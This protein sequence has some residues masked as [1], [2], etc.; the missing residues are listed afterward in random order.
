[1]SIFI[2]DINIKELGPLKNFDFTPG[3]LNL[4]YS[5]NEKGKTIMT[6]FL[7]RSLFKKIKTWNLREISG[8]GKVKL[9]LN[10]SED[11]SF[12]PASKQKLD[13]S[14]SK[15]EVFKQSLARLLVVKGGETDISKESGGKD[16]LK[17][18]L[19]GTDIIDKLYEDIPQVIKKAEISNNI[20]S[21]NNQGKIKSYFMLKKQISTFE[22]LQKDLENKF[23]YADYLQ[24]I[25]EKTEVENKIGLLDK[26]KKYKAYQ[27]YNKG[28]ELKKELDKIPEDVL[29][30]IARL[31]IQSKE[32]EER[33]NKLDEELGKY[34]HSS[35]LLNWLESAKS[36]YNL[37]SQ[38]DKAAPGI[39]SF[40][41]P[42]V[43]FAGGLA[44][45]FFNR[46]I[47]FVLLSS[48][49][50]ALLYILKRIIHEQKKST[51]EELN[52]LKN[53]FLSKFGKEAESY[54]SFEA[55]YNKYFELNQKRKY[56]KEDLEKEK[57]RISSI[58]L[59]ISSK[60]NALGIKDVS[61]SEWENQLT[62]LKKRRNELSL[63]R[64]DLNNRFTELNVKNNDFEENDPGVEYSFDE[65]D[66]INSKYQ[67]IRQRL[68]DLD[69]SMDVLKNSILAALNSSYSNSWNNI[70]N[71]LNNVLT[72]KRKEFKELESE[73]IALYILKDIAEDYKKNEDEVIN[74]KLSS[75]EIRQALKNLTRFNNI[76]LEGDKLILHDEY[77]AITM[78]N[79]STGTREQV[80]L[81]LR[82]GLASKVN[83][84]QPLFLILDDA[85]QHSDWERRP[86]LVNSLKKIAEKGWQ[87]FYFTMDDN[88]RDLFKQN[89]D[90]DSFKMAEL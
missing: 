76:Q 55:E 72:E 6:E 38:N 56:L 57:E 24:T 44:S 61:K 63:Q 37:L 25:K 51:N 48:A 5:K 75:D 4:I 33:L 70:I 23:N 77:S 17:E 9:S 83:K 64:K 49:L 87:I 18:L 80:M 85:F 40:V 14:D 69:N 52:N 15:N 13:V 84:G 89:S 27:I 1:M 42:I 10:G 58:K 3:V 20:I 90:W 46:I 73:I 43:L 54:S 47:S 11:M 67:E 35:E 60:F 30:D 31:I 62:Y 59:N 12:N 26:A 66:K 71:S 16:Y 74:K 39:K 88:I 50:F 41:I 21:G 8:A 28:F 53:E 19:S 68:H 7:I 36:N 79:L 82:I 22:N 34:K 45:M 29:D 32:G 78:D 86:K 65:Y 81:A 2:K